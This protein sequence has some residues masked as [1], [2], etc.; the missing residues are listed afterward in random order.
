MFRKI[1]SNRDPGKTL[2]GELKKEFGIYFERAGTRSRQLLGKYPRQVFT[3]MVIAMLFSLVM[4]FTGMRQQQ[5][6]SFKVKVASQ[7]AASGFGQIIST[8]NAL[9]ALWATQQQVDL[10]L[11]KDTLTHAD[12]LTLN[13]ALT[14]MENLR[15]LIQKSRP[16]SNNSNH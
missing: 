9:Q 12:S 11:K 13:Q 5:K 8:A 7:S 2:G 4:A 6:S 10:L 16:T 15:A 14:Q 3:L 1:T